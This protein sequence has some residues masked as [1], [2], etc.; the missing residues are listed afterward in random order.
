VRCRE[1]LPFDIARALSTVPD[2]D[3]EIERLSE[4]SFSLRLRVKDEATPGRVSG[5]VRLE[6][7]CP[8]EPPV[9]IQVTGYIRGRK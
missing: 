7:D 4:D 5:E 6:T 9:V 2:L 3:P 1:K 8:D